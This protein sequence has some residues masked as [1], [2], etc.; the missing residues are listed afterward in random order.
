MAFKQGLPNASS[1]YQRNHNSRRLQ[2]ISTGAMGGIISGSGEKPL[3]FKSTNTSNQTM[4][5]Q[6]TN[7]M[8]CD[9]NNKNSGYNAAISNSAVVA[10]NASATATASIPDSKNNNNY[11]S[12]HNSS[13]KASANDDVDN[14]DDDLLMLTDNNTITT[15]TVNS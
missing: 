8:N 5:N 13:I 6:H 14:D 1:I 7:Y 15:T 12:N 9:K 10:K 3:T 4:Q 11:N 2:N